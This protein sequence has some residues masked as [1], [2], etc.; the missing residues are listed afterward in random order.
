MKLRSYRSVRVAIVIILLAS[1]LEVAMSYSLS[2]LVVKTTN[3]LIKHGCIVIG[4][5][6]LYAV[7]MFLN[8]KVKALASYF[9]GQDIRQKTDKL[10]Q[11]MSF[12]EYHVKDHGEHLSLYVN[13]VQKVLEL[14]VD[15]YLSMIEKASVTVFIFLSLWSIHYSMAVIAVISFAVMAL[16]PV[17]FQQKLSRYILG[18][19]EAKEGYLAKMRELLQ[20]FDTYLENL[21]FSVFLEKSR[22]AAY[23]Y[24]EVVLKADSFTALM[25]ASLTFVNSLVTIIAL[26]LLSYNVLQGKVG[27]GAF[28]SVTTLLP[29]FGAAVME[30]LSEKEFYRS[31]Q[32]LFATKFSAIQQEV[33]EE[34]IFT[35]SFVAFREAP[36]PQSTVQSFHN[37][38]IEEIHLQAIS[39]DY[40]TKKIRF[41]ESLTFKKGKKYAIMGESGCGK[42]SL[43]KVLVGQIAD[44]AGE[45]YV[46]ET[47]ATQ[48]LFSSLSYVNQTT[49]L[50]NDTIRH[51]ID[52]LGQHSSEELVEMLKRLNL[53][54]FSL[55]DRIEDN[56][57]N[58]SGGQRQR[59]AIAR[60]LLRSK[61]CL[62]LDEATASL[63]QAT[64]E[65]IEEYILANVETVIMISHHLSDTVKEKLDKVIQLG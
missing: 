19:Q 9:V 43:L 35:N 32:T 26:G 31:G 57:K 51:N 15:K 36:Y 56:G 7:F 16:V 20:G 4:I 1:F 44:Y 48:P 38:V 24:S 40:P 46:N 42:S 50:F 6:L 13:D 10:F 22:K 60:A 49:F 37:Q 11:T 21:A 41:P 61:D 12:Q 14:T 52:L 8:M 59:L 28:L 47:V 3:D 62:V 58:L 65:K 29:T 2:L 64:S 55:D 23:Q 27:A 34:K 25:S 63:D 53:D 45:V 39:L 18:V 30:C 5:Y 17:L 33:F 54:E